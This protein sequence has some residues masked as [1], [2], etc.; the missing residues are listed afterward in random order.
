M[1]FVII[2]AFLFFDETIHLTT[3]FG[4][5]LV[6]IS[7]LLAHSD[8]KRGQIPRPVLYTGLAFAV[9][10]QFAMAL[11]VVMLKGILPHQSV[12]VITAQRF[13]FGT[14][15]LLLVYGLRGKLKSTLAGFKPN[16]SWRVTLPGTLLGRQG[17]DL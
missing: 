6:I 12:L 16:R 17:R 8:L 9:L 2:L 4:G 14:V 5:L 11:T 7:I 15:I 1:P 13:L 10:S 3:F